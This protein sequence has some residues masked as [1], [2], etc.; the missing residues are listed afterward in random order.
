MM[1]VD[2]EF[3]ESRGYVALADGQEYDVIL[4]AAGVEILDSGTDLE[5]NNPS[6]SQV[7]RAFLE[8]KPRFALV[9]A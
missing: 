9:C 7:I 6:L 1:I 5:V 8:A 3:G 4:S 2:S